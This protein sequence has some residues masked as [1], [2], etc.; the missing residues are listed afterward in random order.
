HR[1]A[2]SA[3]SGI[4][5]QLAGV[6][7]ALHAIEPSSAPLST[8]QRRGLHVD[9]QGLSALRPYREL[10]RR[11]TPELVNPL[12][13]SYLAGCA[14][15]PEPATRLVV[16][17]ADFKGEHVLLDATASRLVGIIDWA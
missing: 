11:L 7:N 3:W 9:P 2:A 4:A 17:H 16:S 8:L 13:E 12:V 14:R 1:P 5:E 15:L 10:I 6:L